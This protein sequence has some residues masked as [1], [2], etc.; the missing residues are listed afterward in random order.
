MSSVDCQT[1]SPSPGGFAIVAPAGFGKTEYIAD[2][3]CGQDKATLVLTHTN[4]GVDALKRR[5]SQREVKAGYR[6]TTIAAWCEAWVKA[7]PYLTSYDSYSSEKDTNTDAYFKRLYVE[8]RLLCAKTWFRRTLQVSYG[9]VVVDE[10]Q[11][12][13]V[14]QHEMFLGLSEFLPLVVLGDPLQGVLYW[15]KNDPIVDWRN[16]TLPIYPLESQPWRWINAGRPELGDYISSIRNDLMPALNG[17]DVNI[18]LNR[19]CANVSIIAPD[20]LNS[21]Q[22]WDGCGTVAYVTNI[23]QVQYAF[24]QRHINFQ[25]NENVDNREAVEVCAAFDGCTGIALGQAVLKF[26]GKCFTRISTELKSYITRLDKGSFDFSKIRKHPAVGAALCAIEESS[27]PDAILSVLN[28]IKRE[29]EF[30]LYRGVYFGEVC[31]ALKVAS[32]EGINVT[33]ALNVIRAQGRSY[34][35]RT[36][37]RLLSSRTVLSKG[38]EYDTAV[39]SEMLV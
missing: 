16:L 20:A 27:S 25:A 7:Y 37:Y 6:V 12:C 35:V 15:V 11:D 3:A 21:M 28:A 8:M 17:I 2:H 32:S 9:S 5:L 39:V 29:R 4:A 18:S 33:E 30:R 24:S 23:Q 34:E 14:T 19:N 36:P 38:L 26:A 1:T 13:T 10:Y 22:R 31:R